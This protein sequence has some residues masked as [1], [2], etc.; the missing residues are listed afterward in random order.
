MAS[1]PQIRS[2]STVLYPLRRV[3]GHATT[4]VRFCDDTEQR[5]RAIAPRSEF[6]LEYRDIN[7]YELS[8]LLDFF[9][10][11]KG[12]VDTTWDI[13]IGGTTYFHMMFDT[14]R[15]EVSE[16]RPERY[17]VRLPCRQWRG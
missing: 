16:T 15:L 6:I 1:F 7:G 5:W 10:T 14:D 13:Q 12:M 17:T 3:R 9:R 8:E 11:T 2:G 4:V